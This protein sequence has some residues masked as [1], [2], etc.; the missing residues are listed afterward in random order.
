V[1]CYSVSPHD[2]FLLQCFPTCFFI[3]FFPKLSLSNLFF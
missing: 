3:D 2:F 1:D